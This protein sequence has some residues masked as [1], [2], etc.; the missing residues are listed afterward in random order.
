MFE[1]NVTT[2]TGIGLAFTLGMGLLIL[3]LPRRFVLAPLLATAC[4]MTFGQVLMVGPFHFPVIRIVLLFGWARVAIR[5]ELSLDKF[6]AVDKW[7]LAWV[8][9]TLLMKN[10]LWQTSDALINTLGFSYNVIGMYFLARCLIRGLDDVRA[11]V[12]IMAFLSLPLAAAALYEHRTAHNLFSVLGGVPP[13]TLARDDRLRCQ[14]PFGHAILA[15]TFGATFLPLFLGLWLARE[16]G[17]ILGL[18]GAFCATVLMVTSASSGPLMTYLYGILGLM[19]WVLRR[20]MRTVRWG[21]L[22]MLLLMQLL[23][24]A[25]IWFLIGRLSELVGGTGWHRSELIHQAIMRFDEWWLLGAKNTRHWLSDSLPSEPTMVDIT[26]QYIWEA[27]NGG[28]LTLFCFVMITV[29][30]FKALGREM[31]RREGEPSGNRIFLWAMG[32]ALFTHA[33][34][35]ISVSYFDQ[36]IIFWYLLI[37]MIARVAPPETVPASA[38]LWNRA[39]SRPG[40]RLPG[41]Y[42]RH[43][44]L[45]WAPDRVRGAAL[46]PEKRLTQRM[47]RR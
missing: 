28:L 16:K 5:H 6:T 27:V 3:I 21:L 9:A 15:G 30:S 37:A 2:L 8:A 46:P 24:K 20:Y 25:P 41:R 7:V 23:M 17:R 1:T 42:R 13:E 40:P 19:M 10:L 31:Q 45:G 39:D 36:M 33:M 18:A 43:G 44:S 38:G 22:G 14:G 47:K 35:F 4:Y 29:Y 12:K 26:S 11:T 32:T 34:S